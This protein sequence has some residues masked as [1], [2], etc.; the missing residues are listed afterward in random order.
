VGFVLCARRVWPA[1]D[2]A[3]QADAFGERR[4]GSVEIWP[5]TAVRTFVEGREGYFSYGK[6][7][8]EDLRRELAPFSSNIGRP[9]IDPE[10]MIRML[11]I[12]YCFGIRSEQRLCD[13]VHLK[14]GVGSWAPVTA[15]VSPHDPCRIRR[16]RAAFFFTH[17]Q[18]P[19]AIATSTP[20]GRSSFKIVC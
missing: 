4:A 7:L 12:G 5:P 18:L 1:V 16:I 14:A 2:P 13:E 6:L 19:R 20:L 15:R 3:S 8:L 9:S 11:L 10:L 17:G